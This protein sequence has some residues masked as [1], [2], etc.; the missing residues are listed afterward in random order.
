METLTAAR[1]GLMERLVNGAVSVPGEV[2]EENHSLLTLRSRL[3][4]AGAWRLEMG[5]EYDINDFTASLE[6]DL[7][8]SLEDPVSIEMQDIYNDYHNLRSDVSSVLTDEEKKREFCRY[9]FQLIALAHSLEERYRS[10]YEERLM[11]IKL[12]AAP[13]LR[14]WASDYLSPEELADEPSDRRIRERLSSRGA[15]VKRRRSLRD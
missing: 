9:R 3:A 1:A 2:H 4:D 14:T 7:H 10:S 11:E 12:L 8:L 13:D 6:A 5:N 15:G